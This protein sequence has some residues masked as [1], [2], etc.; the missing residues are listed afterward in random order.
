MLNLRLRLMRLDLDGLNRG[1]GMP[2]VPSHLS[3]IHRIFQTLCGNSRVG[4]EKLR[5]VAIPLV[6]DVQDAVMSYKP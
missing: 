5:R 1:S 4:N 2:K 6:V 3:P